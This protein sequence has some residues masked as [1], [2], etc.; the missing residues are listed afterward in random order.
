MIKILTVIGARPQIIKSAALSRAIRTHYSETIQEVLLHTGQ[1]YDQNMSA[2]FFDELDIPQPAYNLEIGSEHPATQTAKMITGIF[3]VIEKEKPN[4]LVIYGDTNSTIAGAIAANK[5]EIPV[6]HIEAGLRSFNKRMPEENN[7]IV[8]DHLSTLLFC[9]TQSAEENLRKEGFIIN[10]IPDFNLD[11][12]GIF[13]CGDIMYDNSLFFG[14]KSESK[15]ALLNDLGLKKGEFIFF[16][17]HRPVNTDNPSA[18]SEIFETCCDLA[19][20]GELFFMPLHP[21]TKKAMESLP[22]ELLNRIKD[23]KRLIIHPPISFLEVSLIE[24]HCKLVMTDSGGV[25]K[26]AY[27]FQKPCVVLRNETEWVELVD[28]GNSILASSNSSKIKQAIQ[29]FNDKERS[30]PPIF[31][32]GHAAEIICEKVLESSRN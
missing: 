2:V 25:Q 9:P 17:C 11:R 23:N 1:H 15:I 26:E 21:R 6:V 27:F 16:T 12:P 30:F 22:G 24:K 10:T 31:G 3:D 8:S 18:L 32:N 19:D 7:R 14:E 5:A 29:S 28:T 13:N 20:S 4:W